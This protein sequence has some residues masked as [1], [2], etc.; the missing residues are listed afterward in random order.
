MTI[1]QDCCG[2]KQIKPFVAQPWR[3][4]EAQFTSSTRDLVDNIEEHDILEEMLEAV[5]PAK[6][7]HLDYLIFTP[8]RYPPLDYGSRFG[9]RFEP[10]LWYGAESL[11]TAF[12][13]FA[14]YRLIFL[15]DTSADLGY[16]HLMLTAFNAYIETA[17]GVDLTDK[18][19]ASYHKQLSD[20]S[21]YHVSQAL[22]QQMRQAGVEAFQ[23]YSAR[24]LAKGKNIAAFLPSVFQKKQG[25][26]IHHPQTWNCIT[27]RQQVEFSRESIL[28]GRQRFCFQAT[29][30]AI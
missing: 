2:E 10:S 6:S 11:Q 5:K 7:D 20:K 16:I 17:K 28:N 23:F 15:R 22:G 1:W 4:V 29:A 3:V 12:A 25:Q 26:Y 14:Y 8:F 19:F 30:L 27:H 21:S 18:A 13:E 9:S 24:C